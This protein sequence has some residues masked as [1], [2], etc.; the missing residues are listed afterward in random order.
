MRV[1]KVVER[2]NKSNQELE[3]ARRACLEARTSRDVAL[4]VFDKANSENEKLE[5]ELSKIQEEESRLTSL[6]S[7]T[8]V[9][10]SSRER[11]LKDQLQKENEL[12]NQRKNKREDIEN[13]MRHINRVLGV[14]L[15]LNQEVRSTTTSF[16]IVT[17][18]SNWSLH[19][20]VTSLLFV[21]PL[22]VVAAGRGVFLAD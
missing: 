7:E 4:E 20:S 22:L 13:K 8:Q 18:Y 6:I 9:K 5:V 1:A 14:V 10:S 15:S 16:V 21:A 19:S 2:C 3:E 17:L 11:L 12:L